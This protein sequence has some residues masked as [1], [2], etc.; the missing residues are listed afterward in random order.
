[1][2]TARAAAA[3]RS[4]KEE[5]RARNAGSAEAARETTDSFGFIQ[6][7]FRILYAGPESFLETTISR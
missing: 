3:G 5:K 7:H 4:T 6:K 1:M 2:K